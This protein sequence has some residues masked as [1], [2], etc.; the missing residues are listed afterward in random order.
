M[1]YYFPLVI[2][3]SIFFLGF[4]ELLVMNEEIL[5]LLCFIA[6]F[7]NMYI[8]FGVPIFESFK[9]TSNI[10]KSNFFNNF[11]AS[12]KLA[13]STSKNFYFAEKKALLFHFILSYG[14]KSEYIC[15][16]TNIFEEFCLTFQSFLEEH[17]K[18][19][20]KNSA[21]TRI[22]LIRTVLAF[23]LNRKKTQVVI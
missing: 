3:F 11:Q 4:S 1:L 5:L 13:L 10:I 20:L 6:F 8:F 23:K 16:K 15:L 7:F 18:Y 12:K 14:L 22:N 21:K 17:Y 2:L 19:G 9:N